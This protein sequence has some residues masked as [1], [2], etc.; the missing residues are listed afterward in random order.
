MVACGLWLHAVGQRAPP[1]RWRAAAVLPILLVNAALPLLFCRWEDTTT[2]VLIRWGAWSGYSCRSGCVA[3]QAAKPLTHRPVAALPC[4]FNVMWLSSFKAGHLHACWQPR[5]TQDLLRYRLRQAECSCCAGN[6]VGAG[7]G[8]A[9]LPQAALARAVLRL[10]H[11]PHHARVWQRRRRRSRP[12]SFSR[13]RRRQGGQVGGCPHG[14]RCRSATGDR[15]SA[16][17]VP[18]PQGAPGRGRRGPGPYAAR[19]AGQAGPGRR[20]SVAAAAPAARPA[21]VVCFRWGAA[22]ETTWMP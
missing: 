7:E 3:A 2:I 19:L 11:L 17:C 16:R 12:T 15:R 20:A 13:P 21:R 4:S 22:A 5:P 6:I 9:V 18:Q 14:W 8:R 10:L 1:G